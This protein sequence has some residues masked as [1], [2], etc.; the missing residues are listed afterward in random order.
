MKGMESQLK[1]DMYREE[2]SQTEEERREEAESR[3][4]PWGD[5]FFLDD[6]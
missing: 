1:W 2:R 5:Q 4:D 6:L 3:R